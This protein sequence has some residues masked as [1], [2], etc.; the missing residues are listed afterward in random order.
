MGHTHQNEYESFLQD[1]SKYLQ[2]AILKQGGITAREAVEQ[3]LSTL[4]ANRRAK[5]TFGLRGLIDRTK[6]QVIA[7]IIHDHVEHGVRLRITAQRKDWLYFEEKVS[8]ILFGLGYTDMFENEDF[9]IENQLESLRELYND[10]G[11]T[12]TLESVSEPKSADGLARSVMNILLNA[13]N[14][15]EG[16][17]ADFHQADWQEEELKRMASSDV[18]RLHAGGVEEI[19]SK[20]DALRKLENALCNMPGHIG[21][22][23]TGLVHS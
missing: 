15:V 11:K 14:W 1:P 22:L 23:L 21:T 19:D 2:T 17:Y 13:T 6:G 8:A 10:I 20:D 4:K 5:P 9:A 16:K 12:K 7:D 3:H 18:L